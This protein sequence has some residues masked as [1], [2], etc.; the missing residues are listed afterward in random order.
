MNRKDLRQKVDELISSGIP[1]S[2]VF[3]RLSGN[4]VGD[5]TLAYAIAAH[6]DPRR[7][8]AHRW[9]I[10]ILLVF[11]YVEVAFAFLVCLGAG[12]KLS[13]L[14]G[15]AAAIGGASLTFLFAWGFQRNNVAAYNAYLILTIGQ[16]PNQLN[17]LSHAPMITGIR[18]AI[19]VG[20][21]AYVWTLRKRL[22]P[23]V[24]FIGPRKVDGVYVFDD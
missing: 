15:L 5:R 1:K 22:F 2:E 12:M 23:D 9:R 16:A 4:D 24:V 14:A 10:R 20:M 19:G 8:E 17:N 18:L 13:P 21:Y 7:C 3:S 11:A 6:I